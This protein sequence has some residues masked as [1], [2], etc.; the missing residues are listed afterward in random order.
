MKNN[1]QSYV[2]EAETRGYIAVCEEAFERQLSAAAD[3]VLGKNGIFTVTLSGPS[4]SGKTTTARKLTERLDRAGVRAH[5]VSIDDFYKNRGD[6]VMKRTSSGEL[7]PDYETAASI[8]LDAFSDFTCRLGHEKTLRVPIFDFRI[9]ERSGYREISPEPGDVIIFE[10][11]QAIYPEIVSNISNEKNVSI[12]ISVGESLTVGGH[13]FTPDMIRLI[14]RL[15]RDYNYRS[16]SPEMTFYLWDEVRDNEIHNIEPYVSG[17][18]VVINSLLPYELGV[19]RPYLL[20][21]LCGLPEDSVY[22][23]RAAE[24]AESVSGISD[25]PLS[26]VPADSVFREFLH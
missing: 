2:T 23:G 7:K 1:P 26:Y 9:G 17:C 20:H 11:I 16:A 18:D 5:M 6:A 15:V 21:A 3:A 12:H 13:T 25:I 22:T 4:C 24:I 8:D 10:G 14:R 19:I